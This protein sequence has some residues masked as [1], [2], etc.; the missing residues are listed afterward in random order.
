MEFEKMYVEFAVN[1]K[2]SDD[3]SRDDLMVCDNA[4]YR[5]NL[6]EIIELKHFEETYAIFR[7][8]DTTFSIDEAIKT[9]ELAFTKEYD[10]LKAVGN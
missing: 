3:F 5:I 8:W 7:L 2:K 6:P 4:W 10:A 9:I 1:L